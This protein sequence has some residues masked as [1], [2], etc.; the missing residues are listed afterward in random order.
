MSLISRILVD[1]RN[2]DK[3][4]LRAYLGA[5]EIVSVKDP[6]F[7][8]VGDGVADDTA[9]I[10]AAID[11]VIYGTS[12]NYVSSVLT[13]DHPAAVF[14]PQGRYRITDTLHCGYGTSFTHC[15]LIGEMDQFYPGIVPTFNDRPAIAI[16]GV[17]S[18]NIRGLSIIGVKVAWLQDYNNNIR[19]R[20]DLASYRGPN[21]GAG[22]LSR[23]APYAGIAVDPYSGTRPGVS[24]PDVHY[25]AFLG[26]ISQYGKNFSSRVVIENCRI[27][28]FAVGVVVQPSDA[29]GN[30]DY[31]SISNCNLSLNIIGFALGNAQARV[32]NFVN[33][34]CSACH[35]AIDSMSFGRQ[36]GNAAGEICGNEFSLCYQL[37]NISMSFTH[38]MAMSNC[39]A[40]SLHRIGKVGAVSAS[41]NP[42]KFLACTFSFTQDYQADEY[43]PPVLLD[44]STSQLVEF[45]SCEFQTT[46]SSLFVIGTA[47][48]SLNNCNIMNG[49]IFDLSTI[50]GKM[51]KS[52]TL[53]IWD[54][55]SPTK[56]RMK[57]GVV[58]PNGTY[59]FSGAAIPGI[60]DQSVDC[61]FIDV[62]E[63]DNRPMPYWTKRFGV[64][65]AGV[66]YEASFFSNSAGFSGIARSGR[67]YSFTIKV[68][69]QIGPGQIP[70]GAIVVTATNLFYVK[71]ASFGATTVDLVLV[72]LTN[73][74]K[75]AGVWRVKPG[76]ELFSTNLY[77]WNCAKFYPAKAPAYMDAIKG[78]ATATFKTLGAATAGPSAVGTLAAG[79]IY[80]GGYNELGLAAS[81]IGASVFQFAKV[82]TVSPET[83]VVTFSKNAV[84]TCVVPYPLF[85]KGSY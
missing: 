70:K 27:T 15:S 39:Y 83:G 3:A 10:Q 49:D 69:F 14:F 26:A 60:P 18:V 59:S 37:L 80:D 46:R 81:S 75:D 2:V 47:R 33:N 68:G 42:L 79:D 57:V 85:V 8:A 56:R 11:F 35:T 20:S 6:A 31:V 25:P 36:I 30:G 9:A 66:D 50:A 4:A 19:D 41:L 61:G 13:E 62:S 1:G 43:T 40:E 44:C 65:G 17:R 55:Y 7:G 64:N 34:L 23:Y 32:S 5:R 21:L 53:G 58:R 22:A 74:R 77:F 63:H 84:L 67:E 52:A 72:Q 45:D 54:D 28:G 82:D 12:G 78:S 48:A 38:A 24:Y 76:S 16:Q 29:D 51:A 73:V 71:R